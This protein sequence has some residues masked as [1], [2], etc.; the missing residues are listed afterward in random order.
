MR[1]CDR[2]MV[3][4][5]EK[6]MV[7]LIRTVLLSRNYHVVIVPSGKETLTTLNS[8]PPDLVLLSLELPGWI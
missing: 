4:E 6:R 1:V 2:I 5:D 3:V 8:Y 7:N